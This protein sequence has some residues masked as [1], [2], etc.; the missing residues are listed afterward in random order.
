MASMTDD[1]L[2]DEIDALRHLVRTQSAELAQARAEASNNEALITHLRLA[3]EKMRRELYGPRS[4]RKARLIEQ[5]ELQLE[6]L[7]A[8]ATEDAL[9]A[10]QA[11][12][13]RA[14]V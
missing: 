5:M 9:V 14:H 3:I 11:E 7:E 2:P 12:I 13:G 6:E 4:E 1:S 10:E 8:D